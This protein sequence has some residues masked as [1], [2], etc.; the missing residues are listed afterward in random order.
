MSDVETQRV[1]AVGA[2][3]DDIEIGC[4]GTLAHM[5][6]RGDEVH[7]LVATSGEAGSN[8]VDVETLGR[9]REGEARSAAEALGVASIEF[10][11]L[12]DGLTG[13]TRDDKLR[14]I[15]LIRKVRPHVVFVHSS[16][17]QHLDHK[18][19]HGLVVAGVA[20]AAGPWFQEA[21]G[22]PWA[23]QTMLGYEVWQPMETF[24]M[25]VDITE[26]LP[27]KLEALRRH[28]SQ[29]ATIPYDDAVEGLGRYRGAMSGA[30]KYVE[31]F[32]ALR[33]APVV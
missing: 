11:R 27:T 12:P 4:G 21:P 18:T 26:T 3:P 10:L 9:T 7:L 19:I 33:L 14:M 8:E 2:H 29:T 31:V 13:F 25:A 23:V 28:A 22:D 24:A 16:R 32:E 17:E 30:G 5:R 20:A 6:A 1:L 15:G